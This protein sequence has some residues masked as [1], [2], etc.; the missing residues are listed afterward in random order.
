M[1]KLL[2]D[3][4]RLLKEYYITGNKDLLTQV[5]ANDIAMLIRIDNGE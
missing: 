4:K 5:K 3:N 1:D 2:E